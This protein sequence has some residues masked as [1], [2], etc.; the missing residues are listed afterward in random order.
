MRPGPTASTSAC[1]SFPRGRARRTLPSTSC[2]A[3]ASRR[4]DAAGRSTWPSIP[5]SRKASSIASP[6][7]SPGSRHSASTA[8]SCRTSASPS[9]AA[10]ISRASPCTPRRRWPCTTA[11][12]SRV[13]RGLGFRRVILARE[14]TLERI[15]ALR[16][17]N[18]DIEIEVFIHGA[19][20]YSFSG[21]CF[22]SWDLTGRS[23]NR[24]ECAQICRS[25]FRIHDAARPANL[26]R[27]GSSFFLPRPRRRLP[28]PR[29]GPHRRRRPQDRRPHEV[30]R[31]RRHDR[32]AL[33]RPHRRRR[34]CAWSRRAAQAAAADFFAA[35]DS[36]IFRGRPRRRR[37]P[38]R[39]VAGPSR[40]GDRQ[41]RRVAARLAHHRPRR[42][43]R[44]ARRAAV[45]SPKGGRPSL[46]SSPPEGCA[47]GPAV[48]SPSSFPRARRLPA[49]DRRSSR[50]RRGPSTSRRSPRAASRCI[51][52]PAAAT[53]ASRKAAWPW[54]GAARCGASLCASRRRCRPSRRAGARRSRPCSSASSRRRETRRCG[55]PRSP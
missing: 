48:R 12:A 39:R 24:G 23:G 33:P 22:A 7:P 8:S 34:G 16:E 29:A 38:R 17:E 11:P 46:C 30:A 45:L 44:G 35:E 14:L 18:P 49:P 31:V 13:L 42:R 47:K 43:P 36:G 10:A 9:S 20:C 52:S 51:G 21:L 55:L 5:S 1:T 53:S 41:S 4:A 26:R 54:P 19:L 27:R 40:G 50:Y 2:D 32:G 25:R 6:S 15:R 3:S 28:R 37:P